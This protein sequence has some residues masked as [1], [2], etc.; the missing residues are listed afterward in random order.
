MKSSPT[1]ERSKPGKYRE[2]EVHLRAAIAAGK[3]APGDRLPSFAEL[4]EQFGMAPSTVSR[5]LLQL[6]QDGLLTRRPG[7]GIYVAMPRQK[8][9]AGVIGFQGFSFQES[10][11]P[12]WI[13]L[14]R[15]IQNAAHE[16]GFEVL[17]LSDQVRTRWDSVDG[18]LLHAEYTMVDDLPVPA[19]VPRVC[20][21]FPSLDGPTVHADDFDGVKRATQF[22]LELGHR[23]IGYLG[24]E[25]SVVIQTRLAGYRAALM[26]AGIVPRPEWVRPLRL[27]LGP[28]VS[29]LGQFNMEV[30]LRDGWAEA[31]CT[32]LLVQN[33]VIAQGVLIAL[34]NAG[35]RVPQDVSVVGY[36]GTEICGETEPT[37]TSVAVPLE[38][39]GAQSVAMLLRQIRGESLDG[40]RLTLPTQVVPR[41]S[42]APPPSA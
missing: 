6:E 29:W 16:A 13:D 30:W 42:T 12:Y 5:A 9:L 32:A 27:Q 19:E 10:Y 26:D 17:L 41:G 36:D 7:S 33:D 38:R 35:I 24:F 28:G 4:R 8:P 21:M 22:L 3:W 1:V 40:I 15:G 31:G 20:V 18:V 37:L 11:L 23:R 2:L 34:K 14:M 25:E 39:I